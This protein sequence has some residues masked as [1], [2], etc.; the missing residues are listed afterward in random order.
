MDLLYINREMQKCD[1]EFPY[2]IIVKLHSYSS[3]ERFMKIVNRFQKNEEKRELNLLLKTPIALEYKRIGY[4]DQQIFE[5]IKSMYY[6]NESIEE[7]NYQSI[8]SI[9][10]MHGA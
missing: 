8:N 6:T 4:T 7:I 5:K 2:E 10:T 3:M 1:H 9:N